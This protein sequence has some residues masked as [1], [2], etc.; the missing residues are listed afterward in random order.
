MTRLQS[1]AE[2]EQL[3]AAILTSRDPARPCIAVCAGAACHGLDSLRV[4]DAFQAEVA[5]LGAEAGVDVR[6]TGCHGY[7][8]KGPNVVVGPAE[9]CY[10]EVKPGDVPEIVDSARTGK[11]IERLVYQHPVTGEKAVHM[12]EVPFYKHQMRLLIGD[13]TRIDPMRIDDYIAVGGYAALSKALFQM[14][15]DQLVDEVKKANL[16]GR[17]GGG[18]PAGAGGCAGDRSERAH[19]QGDRAPGL[20][21][22]GHRR[23]G[24]SHERGAV[25]QA[26][27]ATA[28]R[29]QHPHRPDAH[30]RLH[31]GGRLCGA[32]QGAVPDDARPDRRRGEEG[33]PA[34]AR[35][36]R[37]PGRAEMGNHPE[38]AQRRKIRHRQ[39]PRGRTGRLHG[40]GP[41][42]RQ[43]AQGARGPDHRRRRH[44]LAPRL[45][46][47]APRFAATDQ[48][49]QA[50]A[51]PGRGIRTARATTSW[52]PASTSTSNCTSTS[53]SSSPANRAR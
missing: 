45:H 6:V 44:R 38:R 11:V 19:R 17:G 4:A 39:R 30:R 22:P 43:S 41:L 35:R 16:R 53:A 5:K 31:R 47:H 29:R 52:A 9:V 49:H 40:P 18:F 25:L 3:R 15:P 24:R 27:D 20:C 12:N 1:A 32:G 10:F 36:R 14:T 34:R 51:G 48:A 26:P 7:C 2:L 33:Q 13:N 23:E 50:G 42:H 8:E 21:Q 46:L 37:L 28:D